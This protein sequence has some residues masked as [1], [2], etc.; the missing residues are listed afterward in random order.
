[1]SITSEALIRRGHGWGSHDDGHGRG[2]PTADLAAA[3]QVAWETYLPR[4]AA[5]AAGVN[6]GPDPH[7]A[8]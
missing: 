3:H 7:S 6:P 1:V 5:V 2:S 4:L 8:S